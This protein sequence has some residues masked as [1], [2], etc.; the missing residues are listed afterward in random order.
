[1]RNK[2]VSLNGDM[3]LKKATDFARLDGITNFK[4]TKGYLKGLKRRAGLIFTKK[5]GESS[6][7][8]T[9]FVENWSTE[10]KQT[11]DG[12]SPENV[13]N[14][15]ETALFYRLLPSKTYSFSDESSHGCKK[16]KNR[17]TAVLM[18]NADG[19]DRM[20]SIIGKSVNPRAFRGHKSLPIDYYSQHNSWLNT[21]IF[22]KIVLK[23]NN[24]MKNM[25][26]NV[27]LFLDNFSAHSVDL[28]LSNVKLM[29]FPANSTSVLQPL[30]QGIIH[31]F[32]AHYRKE[33]IALMISKL[34]VGIDFKP[35]SIDLFICM[36]LIKQ[37]LNAV[38]NQTIINCFN[39]SRFDFSNHNNNTE[40]ES[41]SQEL[42]CS[43]NDYN[44]WEKL[45][46]L[47]NIDFNSF[48]SYVSIDSQE[49]TEISEDL[50]DEQIMEI[51]TKETNDNT[52]DV[53]DEE[54]DETEETVIISRSQAID[55]ITTLQKYFSQKNDNSFDDILMEMHNHVIKDTFTSLKQQK[56]TDFF[57]H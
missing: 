23:F 26:K 53:T 43:E 56:I 42:N 38:T 31:S 9:N 32:K 19:S 30:D 3:I 36:N 5:H 49:C 12:Y 51:I 18:T 35:N 21:D 14:L 52:I 8:D 57:S 22:R 55:S 50:S 54:S 29:F 48:E 6:S 33:L 15:D 47:T 37:S 10:L 25:N 20:C 17:I 16:S 39:K 27:L 2:N 44:F 13:Y 1:M 41:Q 40:C 24:R 7:V 46:S 11:I 28:N 4:P 34:E 45:K